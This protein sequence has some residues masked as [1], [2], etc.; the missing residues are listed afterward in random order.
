MQQCFGEQDY[1]L[2]TRT[3]NALFTQL[4]IADY[5]VVFFS[6]MNLTVNILTFEIN[7]NGL[8]NSDMIGWLLETINNVTNIFMVVSLYIKHDLWLAW[9][10]SIE[11][12]SQYDTLIN[13]G[14]WKII[15]AEIIISL[16]SPMH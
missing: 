7:R 4:S 3:S 8:E 9:S 15:L 6:V 12:Y 13:T 5:S 16:I 14:A 11:K 2:K 1:I 10:I